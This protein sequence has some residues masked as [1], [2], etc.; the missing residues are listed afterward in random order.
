MNFRKNIF[1]LSHRFID[2]NFFSYY[3]KF[4]ENQWKSYEELE[5][6]QDE[7]IELIIKY[8]YENIE[9]YRVLF[10]RLNIKPE[11][12]KSSTDLVKL[13]ILTKEI[14]KNKY[15]QFIPRNLNKLKYYNF[16]TGGTTGVPFEFRMSKEQRIIRGAL[17]YRGWGYGGYELSDSMV[18]LAGRSLDIKI[19]SGIIS[20]LNQITRNIKKLPSF[21][22]TEENLNKYKDLINFI[23]PKFIRGYSSAIYFF[24]KWLKKKKLKIMSPVAVFTTSEKLYPNMRDLITEVFDTEVYDGYSLGDGGVSAYECDRHNGLHIDTEN[25]FLE[26][27]DENGKRVINNNGKIIATS[28]KNFAMPFLRYDTGDIGSISDKSCSCGRG[29]RILSNIVG[30]SVDYL[31]TP[32]GENIHGWFFLY[33]FWKY[34]KGIKQYQVIQEKIDK[35]IIK[36]VKEKGFEENQIEIIR[37]IVKEKSKGWELEFFFVDEIENER[38][39][40]YKFIVNK[41][42]R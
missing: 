2:K 7:K 13:P 33:I 23:K 29:Y 19:E 35:I 8:S 30:R 11:D 21:D 28:L 22:M 27:V 20:R 26:V 10:D 39:G 25:A 15:N 24:A 37:N 5:K 9:Y 4:K 14:I 1:I 42:K 6:E 32:E 38:S 17:I 18:F 40:K 41:L 36:I 31:I 34:F 3:K 12:I 16:V